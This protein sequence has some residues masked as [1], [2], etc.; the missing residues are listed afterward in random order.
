MAKKKDPQNDEVIKTEETEATV[1][2]GAT[3]DVDAGAIDFSASDAEEPV[4]IAVEDV[5]KDEA[6][7]AVVPEPLPEV[8]YGNLSSAVSGKPLGKMTDEDIL[9]DLS[10]FAYIQEGEQPLTVAADATALAQRLEYTVITNQDMGKSSIQLNTQV[11]G[12]D[13]GKYVTEVPFV[14]P[15]DAKAICLALLVAYKK[16]K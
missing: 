7:S 3:E 13:N 15:N 8:D 2:I 16:A 4:E 12:W 1:D 14:A 9:E 11:K 10:E 6:A 5:T